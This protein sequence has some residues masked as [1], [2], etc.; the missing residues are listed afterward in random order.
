MQGCNNKEQIIL[1]KAIYIRMLKM[2]WFKERI[3]YVGHN[4]YNVKI[5]D[6]ENLR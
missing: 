2:E 4:V 6:K 3:I 1:C 5:I